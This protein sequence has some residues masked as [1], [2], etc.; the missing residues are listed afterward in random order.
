M[1]PEWK[2]VWNEVSRVLRTDW[3]PIGV[4]TPVDEY[5]CCVGPVVSLLLQ[6]A[7]TGVI[8]DYLDE[9]AAKHFGCPMPR[10]VHEQVA[11][12]LGVLRVPDV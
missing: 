2:P 10:E 1:K 4:P 7:S 5:D 12:K 8:A 6:K 9:Q 3:D 11:A